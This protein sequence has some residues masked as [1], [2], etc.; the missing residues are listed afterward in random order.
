MSRRK[1]PIAFQDPDRTIGVHEAIAQ[2]A[3]QERE[4]DDGI[5]TDPS[6]MGCGGGQ[7]QRIGH[8]SV[9]EEGGVACDLHVVGLFVP[10]PTAVISL[11]WCGVVLRDGWTGG[12]EGGREVAWFDDR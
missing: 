12:R 3:L 5:E 8:H 6:I 2:G 11:A 1:R 9:S 4:D 7:V 10:Y